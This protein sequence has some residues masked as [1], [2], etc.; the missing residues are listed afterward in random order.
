MLYLVILS[1]IQKLCFH[2]MRHLLCLTVGQLALTFTIFN[3]AGRLVIAKMSTASTKLLFTEVLECT[4]CLF[5]LVLAIGLNEAS[6]S[7]A[8]IILWYH[9]FKFTLRQLICFY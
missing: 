5:V 3:L 2:S 4:L 1:Y 7:P 6:H 8:L 9:A